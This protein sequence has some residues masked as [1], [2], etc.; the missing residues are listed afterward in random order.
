[1][2]KYAI[3]YKYYHKLDDFRQGIFD[4]LDNCWNSYPLEMQNSI[5]HKFH[6]FP[7]HA[8]QSNNSG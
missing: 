7:E 3:G 6:L 4:F 1:M 2:R 8:Y 5:C